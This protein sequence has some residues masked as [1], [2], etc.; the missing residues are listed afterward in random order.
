MDIARA[1]PLDEPRIDVPWHL[2]EQ[3]FLQLLRDNPPQKVTNGHYQL[4]CRLLGL[5]ES[6]L[7]FHF[8]PRTH[9]RLTQVE[10]YRNPQHQKKKGFDEL[11]RA[12]EDRLGP[13]TRREDAAMDGVRPAF[14]QLGKISVSH[15][16]YYHGDHH[17]KVLFTTRAA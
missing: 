15:E 9:G 7:H 17:E 5:P 10:F 14:W 6:P 1:L 3:G 12:L 11:Q 4:R 16:Y 8:Q 2:T 13:P